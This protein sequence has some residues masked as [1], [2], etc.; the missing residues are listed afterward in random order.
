[1]TQNDPCWEI[2]ST[3]DVQPVGV[4]ERPWGD[5]D[6]DEDVDSVDALSILRNVAALQVSQQQPCPQIGENILVSEPL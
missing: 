2:G 3:V 4:V 1:L 6:C 5:V